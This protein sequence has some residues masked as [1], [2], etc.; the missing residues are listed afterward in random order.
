MR[1]PG[2]ELWVR[3][4][5]N[6]LREV[7]VSASLV[8]RLTAVLAMVIGFGVAAGTSGASAA[9]S[10]SVRAGATVASHST[11]VRAADWWW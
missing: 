6:S 4:V 9:P 2:R 10:T 7:N 11:T 8:R 5:Q 1:S 3:V